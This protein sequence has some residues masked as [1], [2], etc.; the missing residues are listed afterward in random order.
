MAVE[1]INFHPE[2]KNLTNLSNQYCYF[3]DEEQFIQEARPGF[4]KRIVRGENLELWFWRIEGGAPGSI[5]HQHLMNEQI[6]II[7]R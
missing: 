3:Y 2:A 6:G 7:V 4:K 1:R 5:V